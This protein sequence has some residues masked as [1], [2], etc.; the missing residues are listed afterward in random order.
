MGGAEVYC[1]TLSEALVARGHNVT[2][3]TRNEKVEKE[4]NEKVAVKRSLKAFDPSPLSGILFGDIYNPFIPDIKEIVG[5]DFDLI[6]LH[7]I[8]RFSLRLIK[9]LASLKIP[10]LWTIHDYWIVCPRKNLYY[11][12]QICTEKR[13]WNCPG[14]SSLLYKIVLP[15]RWSYFK[16]WMRFD[17][18]ISHYIASSMYVKKEL[19]TLDI[20]KEKIA[21]L[22]NGINVEDFVY[23]LPPNNKTI[24]FIGRIAE[25]K[26]IYYFIS[27]IPKVLE[28][29][30][31]AKF[32][33]VGE[34][35]P[36]RV[37]VSLVK[38]LGVDDNVEFLGKISN[39]KISQ[40]YQEVDVVVVPSIWPENCS[41]V[42]LESHASGRPVIAT[43]VGGNPELVDDGKTGYVIDPKNSN[44]I[45]EKI[46]QILSDEKLARVMSE[47]ARKRAEKEFDIRTHVNS[48]LEIYRNVL[49]DCH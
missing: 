24:L 31:Q 12:N 25:D 13:C 28:I 45:A 38:K 1:R 41:I 20:N 29:V 23:T 22:H 11:N 8:H 33:I 7:N 26:G 49:D 36:K 35:V 17:K 2:V 40:I 3:L 30:P 34:G 19:I 39:E 21:H 27:A 32:L 44:Q 10:I 5:D 37:L 15:I 42:I 48:I 18:F 9:K 4:L 43:N 46:V 14:T 6:H 16:N 47:N